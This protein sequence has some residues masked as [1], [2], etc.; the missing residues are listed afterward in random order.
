MISV[1]NRISVRDTA[2]HDQTLLSYD[3]SRLAKRTKHA[4]KKSPVQ[5][6]G[7]LLT[8]VHL[9]FDRSVNW[10]FTLHYLHTWSYSRDSSSYSL[11][12]LNVIK[13]SGESPVLWKKGVHR[14]Q[15]NIRLVHNILIFFDHGVPYINHYQG[16]FNDC[17]RVN[18][19][20]EYKLISTM[21][22]I[23]YCLLTHSI[24]YRLPGYIYIC[25][26]SAGKES[27]NSSLCSSWSL[28]LH[29]IHCMWGWQ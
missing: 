14:W 5:S 18:L 8:T 27:V 9:E 22:F 10:H 19:Y 24:V 12:S 26:F 28:P 20:L 25:R 3:G 4:S 21:V 11:W 23:A 2:Q 6:I 29:K 1:F 15:C 7:V 16:Y 17:E 13:L